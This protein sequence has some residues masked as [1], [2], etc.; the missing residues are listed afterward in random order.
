M[1]QRKEIR[2]ESHAAVDKDSGP[3]RA[4]LE[5]QKSKNK[6]RND[7]GQ[8][9]REW[10]VDVNKSIGNDHDQNGLLVKKFFQS[11]KPKTAEK[12]FN[13][14]KLGQINHF[15]EKPHF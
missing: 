4:A 7:G 14:K 15:K 9:F 6:A 10:F 12:E 1:D 11:K 13:G 8:G 5:C 2:E 3:N